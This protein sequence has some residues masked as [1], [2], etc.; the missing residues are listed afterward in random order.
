MRRRGGPGII[1]TMARTAVIAG[2]A[3]KVAGSVAI[4]QHQ[5]LA[6]QQA[7]A[8]QAAAPEAPAA[9][10]AAA[11]ASG[12]DLVGELQKLAGLRDA[13]ILTEEEFAAAK[14]RLLG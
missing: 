7:A 2:T 12:G 8:P 13:G 1:S 10:P 3:Q 6:A 14:A 11:P 9:A 4:K 5:Q